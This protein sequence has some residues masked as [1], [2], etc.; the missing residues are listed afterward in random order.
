MVKE[1][2]LIKTKLFL[3]ALILFSVTGA[4]GQCT[5]S[6]VISG[7]QTICYNTLPATLTETTASTG[8]GTL[9]SQWQSSTDNITFTNIS[10]ATSTTYSPTALTQSTWYKR[11][12][13]YDSIPIC[14]TNV[15]LVTVQSVPTAGTISGVQ[16]ICNGGDPVAFTSTAGTGSGTISYRWE[17]SISPFSTWTTI[18]SATA[19]TYDVPSGLTATTQYR[20][21]T[22]STQ[23]SVACESVPTATVQVTVNPTSIGGTASSNHTICYGGTPNDI[24]LTGNTGVIQWQSSTDNVT[25]SNIAGAT[26]TPLTSAQMGSLTATRYYRAVVTSGVCTSVNSTVVTVTI[27]PIK[28]DDGTLLGYLTTSTPPGSNVVNVTACPQDGVPK[29]AFISLSGNTGAI[30]RWEY[31]QLNILSGVLEWFPFGVATSTS[32]T[33]SDITKT[34]SVR[35]V[36]QIGNC[37]LSYSRPFIMNVIPPNIKPTVNANLFSICLGGSVSV[38]ATSSFATGGI[39]GNGGSFE[40]SNPSGWRVDYIPGGAD[41]FPASASSTTPNN[42]AIATSRPAGRNFS[43]TLYNAS[44][45]SDKYAIVNGNP[46]IP[47]GTGRTFSTLETPIFNTYGLTN[48][49]LTFDQAYFLAATAFLKIELSLDGGATYSITLDPGINTFNSLPHNF[50]GPS[51]S[52]AGTHFSNFVPTTINLQEYIGYA[53]LRVRFYYESNGTTTS[54]W[55]LDNI[56]IPDKPINEVLQ[57]TD[58]EGN[59]ISSSENISFNPPIPGVQKYGVTSL[60]DGCRSSGPDGTTFITVNTTNSYAGKNI[61]PPPGEC[62]TKSVNLHAY[63]NRLTAR[64]NIGN[65]AFEG[66]LITDPD[67]RLDAPGTMLPSETPGT[68][69]VSPATNACG[70][71]TF[72]NINDPNATFSGGAGTY[73]LT[74]SVGGCPSA[75]IQVTLED[76]SN[77]NFDGTNDYVTFNNSYNLSNPF[78]I[79]VWVKPNTLNGTIFSKRD[80]SDT[81]TGYDLK[82]NAGI[83]SFNWNNTGSI[84]SDIAITTNRW[85]HIAVTFNGTYRLYIDGIEIKNSGNSVP[86]SNNSECLLGK[87][88]ATPVNYFNGWMDELRIWNVALTSEQLR[89]MMNQEIKTSGTNVIGEVVSLA[90][91]GLSWAN[92]QGYYRMNVGCGLLTAIKGTPGNLR[93]I[94]SPQEDSAPIPYTSGRNGTWGVTTTW[95]PI[96]SPWRTSEV[97]ATNW[98]TNPRWAAPNST[99]INGDPIDWNIVRTTHDITSGTRDITVLG[100]LSDSGKLTM[101]GVTDSDGTGTGQGL[102]ITHYLK[103]N[104]VIDLEGES[105]LVQKR[106]TPAQFSESIFDTSSSGYIERDQQGK[107]NSFNYNYWSSPVSPQGT[108]NN[109]P[110]SVGSILK[111]GSISATPIPIS[112]GDGAYFAD[113]TLTSPIKI[114]NRWIY[115]YNSTTVGNT[116]LQNYYQWNYKGSTGSI[117][118]GEGFSMKG[119]GGAASITALQNYVF[120][121]KP[122]SGTILLSMA[123]GRSYL[124][125][126]PYP[127]ALDADEFILDNIKETINGKV[128]RNTINVFNGALYFWDHFISTNNHLLAQYEG[129][130]A[131]YTLIGSVEAIANLSLGANTGSHGSKLSKRYIPV[132]QGFFI[133]G[134][135]DPAVTGTVAVTS[136]DLVFKNSQRVFEREANGSSIFLRTSKS[137]RT[138][139]SVNDSKYVDSRPKIRLQFDS[140]LGYRRGLLIGVD[141]RTT[142]EFDI[143]FDAPL[144]E[145]NKEDMFWLIGKGKLVIQGVNNFNKN[146][147]LTLGLRIDKAGLVSI[148]ID[149]LENIDS[150]TELYIKDSQSGETYNINDR[151]FEIN[152][153]KGVYL[154]RFSLVFQPRLKRLDE[155]SLEEGIKVFMNNVNSTLNIHKIVDTTINEVYL[156]SILG[157]N[158]K[159]WNANFEE[160]NTLLPIY[161][162]ATGIYLVHVKTTNGSIVKRVYIE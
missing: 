41:I 69:S 132:G 79:S 128:G 146:Q 99:G 161:D 114:S 102:W 158:L 160:R 45:N 8:T 61:A 27:D 144:N 154:E 77:V 112:F 66:Y 28:I 97:L 60:I 135:L 51:T 26:A 23:N 119:T 20:R 46:G 137:K 58:L 162:I 156:Y 141:E 38:T 67:K 19:A 150:S 7:N 21:I 159:I 59:V 65:G 48:P 91:N 34:T 104:G 73:M 101:N 6:G 5:S 49:N 131:T 9:T 17:S 136:G 126:N 84:A 42:F 98:D 155:I 32:N 129:G 10:G 130:Y 120:E 142:N 113:G 39:Y 85:Y 24:T 92:L 62:G 50:T 81:S 54:S 147:E 89:Q 25:F 80:P 94:T 55:A 140:P 88:N 68:W 157:Q 70:D 96:L 125:G 72:S 29:D 40:S 14:E 121:G 118:A 71:P 153:E 12:D 127:S 148:K 36:T 83:I 57:W 152:L 63:D 134:T 139:T 123:S 64:E 18:A 22:I 3:F 117:G 87:T 78:S 110:Y 115:S 100:L 56:K 44:I 107:K 111:D 145:D 37:A 90:I 1:L 35:V 31:S 2:L 75:S 105:Q 30:V 47:T 43:G 151:A 109:A 13:T 95:R 15:V 11:V 53:N 143:G 16:T 103:L 82:I 93:N 4:Y 108:A 122:H 116:D 138:T 33:F 149:E 133:D 106:Y 76:C 124:I 74:W 86:V 52:G